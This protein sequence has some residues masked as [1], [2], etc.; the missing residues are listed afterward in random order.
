SNGSELVGEAAPVG[1][2]RRGVAL[3]TARKDGFLLLL[4]QV[5]E[6]RLTGG[7]GVQWHRSPEPVRRHHVRRVD[8]VDVDEAE[9]ACDREVRRLAGL[10]G[11]QL[12][13]GPAAAN[14]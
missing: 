9:A 1:D 12:E 10:L 14:E 5:R 8:L 2:R 6:V 4:G 3:E 7:G 11:E 13:D